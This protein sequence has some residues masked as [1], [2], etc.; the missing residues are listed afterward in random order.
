MREWNNQEIDYGYTVTGIEVNSQLAADPQAYPV[1]ATAEKNGKTETFEAKY[2]LV[3]RS[4]LLL[5]LAI[6]QPDVSRPAMVLI[7]PFGKHSA[8]T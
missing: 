1:K 4:Q 2:A 3:C 7:V 8:T 6:G 5:F